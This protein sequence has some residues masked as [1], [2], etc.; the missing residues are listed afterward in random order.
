MAGRGR[1]KGLP[2]SG[3]RQKGMPNK[4][5]VARNLALR[6]SGLL[7]LD[8]MISIMRD[9]TKDLAIRMSAANSAAP[10]VHA[11]LTAVEHSGHIGTDFDR[12]DVNQIQAWIAQR[13]AALLPAPRDEGEGDALDFI[14]TLMP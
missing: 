5:T 9:E 7:P 11:K 14:R 10:Y 6:D 12:M 2:K 4:A 13:A 3:G 1:P 8:F